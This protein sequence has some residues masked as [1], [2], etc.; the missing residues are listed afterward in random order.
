MKQFKQLGAY[1]L[2]VKDNKIVLIKKKGGPYDNL[3]DLPGGSLEW[4][5]TPLE[6]LKRELKEE[7]GVE[8][9][10]YEL[11]DADSVTFEWQYK[12]EMI[13]GHHIGIF[14]K[15]LEYDNEIRKDVALDSKNNDSL[16]A[17]FYEISKLHKEDLSKIAVLA[18]EKLGYHFK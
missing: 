4:H 12:D 17:E 7:I 8:V 11:F 9:K 2:I 10:K 16:G 18:L 5:E 1:G 6:A 14:Y 13:D 3:L 15:V